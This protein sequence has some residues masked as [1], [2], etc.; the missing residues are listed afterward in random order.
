MKSITFAEIAERRAAL[1]DTPELQTFD[2]W[3][4]DVEVADDCD[5]TIADYLRMYITEMSEPLTAYM[6]NVLNVYVD[7]DTLHYTNEGIADAYRLCQML[8]AECDSGVTT[9]HS[10]WKLFQLG[11]DSDYDY[12]GSHPIII[13]D[14]LSD[15]GAL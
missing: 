13:F 7:G 14:Y 8:M 12:C 11:G 9:E 5:E 2:I 6:R 10:L 15:I 1:A 3:P 4:V